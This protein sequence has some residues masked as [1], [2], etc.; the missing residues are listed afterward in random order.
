MEDEKMK[1]ECVKIAANAVI[2]CAW[3]VINCGPD[4]DPVLKFAN[5]LYEFIISPQG[6][7]TN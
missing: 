3:Q 1:L 5:Q 7:P 4:E 2:N 6:K